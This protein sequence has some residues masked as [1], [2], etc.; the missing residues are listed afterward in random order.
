MD[1]DDR[2]HAAVRCFEYFHPY[3]VLRELVDEDIHKVGPPEITDL[4]RLY[5]VH[6]E[7]TRDE[8]DPALWEAIMTK[9]SMMDTAGTLVG[10]DELYKQLKTLVHIMYTRVVATELRVTLNRPKDLE[11]I[12]G[13]RDLTRWLRVLYC[14][15]PDEIEHCW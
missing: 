3:T 10:L 4:A 15:A 13:L 9:I 2:R 5:L 8:D 11:T 12:E 14:L 6:E 7:M 1:Y